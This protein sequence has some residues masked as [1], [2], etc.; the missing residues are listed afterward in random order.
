LQAK[1]VFSGA[2]ESTCLCLGRQIYQQSGMIVFS[3]EN[4]IRNWWRRGALFVAN[5]SISL[6][7]KGTL[8]KF[9]NCADKRA[10][11]SYL[12][13]HSRRKSNGEIP[14]GL[15]SEYGA[16]C[17]DD[18]LRRGKG[19]SGRIFRNVE[20]GSAKSKFSPGP[21]QKSLTLS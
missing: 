11:S 21:P 20:D 5:P 2:T 10:N 15:C 1:V 6:R 17:C 12:R 8:D 18:A 13:E 9:G 3:V 16:A 14:N 7:E 19:K 4:E